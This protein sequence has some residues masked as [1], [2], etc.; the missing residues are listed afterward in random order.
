MQ[1]QEEEVKEVQK[2]KEGKEAIGWYDKLQTNNLTV[3]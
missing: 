1:E 3:Y 2:V